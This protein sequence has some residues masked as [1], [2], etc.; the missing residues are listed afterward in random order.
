[1][2]LLTLITLNI[3]DLCKMAQ[4]NHLHLKAQAT[5]LPISESDPEEFSGRLSPDY[6]VELECVDKSINANKFWQARAFGKEVLVK[7]GR[8]GTN[9][10]ST[11]QHFYSTKEA[12]EYCQKMSVEKIAKG[13]K[14]REVNQL[15][16]TSSDA[17]AELNQIRKRI[18]E[19]R[20]TWSND[21]V[22][23]NIDI[24]KAI[25]LLASHAEID[26]LVLAP[27]LFAAEYCIDLL[28]FASRLRDWRKKYTM[29]ESRFGKI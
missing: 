25:A 24:G 27:S 5:A 10:R 2:I 17:L 22:A 13:Y 7:Y 15:S 20:S 19:L 16:I 29:H 23:S 6:S 26:A 14:L 21:P 1:M 8:I 11:V 28:H 18:S 3:L 4:Y 9:G 12:V